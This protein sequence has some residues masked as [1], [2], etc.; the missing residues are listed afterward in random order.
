MC[1]AVFSYILKRQY[2]TK[3]GRETHNLFCTRSGTRTHTADN[4]QGI[5]SPSCLP[6]HHSGNHLR[7]K[8]SNLFA[9]RKI[10]SKIVFL[11]TSLAELPQVKNADYSNNHVFLRISKFFRTLFSSTS[12][13]F[14]EGLTR[15]VR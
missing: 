13:V 7:C 8:V 12:M 9:T 10:F 1:G 4:G 14:S 3:R 11:T 6:F 15:I 2:I 5:L